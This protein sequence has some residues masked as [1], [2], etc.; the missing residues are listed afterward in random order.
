M[1][2]TASAHSIE[3]HSRERGNPV[4]S[5]RFTCDRN[6]ESLGSRVRGNDAVLKVETVN[7]I[8]LQLSGS[9]GVL[10]NNP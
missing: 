4:P 6:Q 3:R 10:R 9:D 7:R 1:T 8:S 5:F 2:A